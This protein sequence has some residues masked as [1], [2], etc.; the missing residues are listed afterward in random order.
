MNTLQ[1]VLSVVYEFASPEIIYRVNFAMDDVQYEHPIARD[2]IMRLNFFPGPNVN[3]ED[4]FEDKKYVPSNSA[5]ITVLNGQLS[6][7]GKFHISMNL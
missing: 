2:E 5:L 4:E 7:L 3:R 6:S 1:S